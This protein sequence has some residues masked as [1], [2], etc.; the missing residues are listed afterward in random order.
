ML[1]VYLTLLS[2]YFVYRLVGK[3]KAWW[4]MLACGVFTGY[5][6]WV[7]QTSVA[8]NFVYNFFHH[9]LA[10][11]EPDPSKGF[12]ALFYEHFTGTGFFE[13]F[14]KALPLLVLLWVA[15]R[16]SPEMRTAIAIEEPLDRIL[17]GAASGGGF[18]VMETWASMCRGRW[19][20]F[21][22]DWRW[23]WRT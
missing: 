8:L 12:L 15:T 11:G 18:A 17:L 19:C 6:L 3:A 16:V 5:Y 22:R 4:V 7:M 9:T 20:S 1:S 10:G 23:T 2:L 13:E 14:V 21:G